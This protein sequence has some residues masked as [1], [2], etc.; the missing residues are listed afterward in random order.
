MVKSNYLL[1]LTMLVLVFTSQYSAAELTCNLQEK[2]TPDVAKHYVKC[3]DNEISKIKNTLD[4][5]IAKRQYEIEKIENQPTKTQILS[6]FNRSVSNHEKYIDSSCQ[7][8]YIAEA[9]NDIK[10]AISYKICEIR[11][12]NQFTDTLKVPF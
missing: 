6:L 2:A 12:I 9:P 1:Q 7:W 8:R 4:T 10:A 3:L 11:L 5:W